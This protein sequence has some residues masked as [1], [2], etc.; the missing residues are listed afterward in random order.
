MAEFN[1]I[2][3]VNKLFNENKDKIKELLLSQL[4]EIWV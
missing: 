1:D 4:Q 2:D 3:S